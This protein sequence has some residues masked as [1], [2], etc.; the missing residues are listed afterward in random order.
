MQCAATLRA[1]S[2]ALAVGPVSCAQPAPPA[3]GPSIEWTTPAGGDAAAR[4]SPAAVITSATVSGL[5]TAWSWHNDELPLRGDA[6]S[7]LWPGRFQATPVMIGGT[8]YFPTPFNRVIALDATTGREKWTFDP[9]I[10]R[11]GPIGDDR[12]GFV[13]RG[14]ALWTGD[15]GTGGAGTGDSGARVL[16]ASRWWLIA[17]DATTGLPIESFG[18]H[19]RVDLSRGLR[20]P[21]DRLHLGHTS[22]PAVWGDVVIVGSSIADGL[23]YE[24][25]PPGD[26]QAF[27]VRTGRRLWRWDPVPADGHADRATWKDGAADVTG[28]VNVWT[29]MSVDAGRG[30]VYVPVST[31]SNDWYGGRRHGDNRYADSI[32]CLEAATGRLVWHQ[33][34]VHHGIWDYEPPAAGVLATIRP[35]ATAEPI[36]AIFVAGKTGFLYAFDRVTGVPIWPMPEK[37]VPATTVPGESAAPTQPHPDW[38]RPFA[39]QGF[40]P[41]D[42]IDFTPELRQQAL[43][44]LAGKTVGPIFT[45]PSLSGTVTI[46]GWIGG[47]GWGGAALDPERRTLFVKGTNLAVLARLTPDPD[48]GYR[49][50]PG[51]AMA[52]E[53]PLTIRLP[54]WLNWRGW[55]RPVRLPI[56]KPPYG[57]LTAVNIDS[58]ET[59]WQVTVGDTPSLRDHPALR[60]LGLPPLGVAGAPGGAATGGGLVFIT[61]GGSTLYAIDSADGRVRGSIPLDRIGYSNPM[62]Y[63]LGGRQYVVVATGEGT[64]AALRAFVL[65]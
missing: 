21:I 19:G 18:D 9:E 59:R 27:D 47:G 54:G 65:R 33:Q 45:P 29:S 20:W 50:D 38:P 41:D 34:L 7:L 15:K 24:R 32:V 30:L 37:P 39:R 22:P 14:V 60:D 17:L 36:D 3:G 44:I 48:A 31:P 12:G 1:V 2:L 5:S 56:M 55:H 23:I 61:G 62:T 49:L 26:V 16:L 28:H 42:V 53:Q 6:G 63:V 43:A 64:H 4:W 13:H 58:G 35:T 46:P 8:L 40:S 11:Y 25:D 10:V 51:I 52:P 57:T